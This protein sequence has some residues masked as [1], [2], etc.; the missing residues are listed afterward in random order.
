MG[1]SFKCSVKA[2]RCLTGLHHH[3]DLS[4]PSL[5]KQIQQV[6]SSVTSFRQMIRYGQCYPSRATEHVFGFSFYF[7]SSQNSPGLERG[8]LSFLFAELYLCGLQA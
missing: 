7:F 4:A 5:T 1:S 6:A 2:I 8:G 3:L